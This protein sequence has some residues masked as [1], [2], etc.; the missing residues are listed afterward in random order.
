MSKL[1]TR[2]Q[3]A[4]ILHIHPVTCDKL[5]K[6]GKLPFIAIG[7]KIFFSEELLQKFIE[8]GGTK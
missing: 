6:S 5:R 2:A 3:A 7:H 4:R 1:L 8:N